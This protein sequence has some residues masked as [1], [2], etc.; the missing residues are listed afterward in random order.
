[1][2]LFIKAKKKTGNL[3]DIAGF[4]FYPGKN[5]GAFGDGGAITTNDTQISN[6]IKALRN[7]G[8]QNQV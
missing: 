8:F 1:M 7:Y 3:G 6:K 4:S 2:E 5:L